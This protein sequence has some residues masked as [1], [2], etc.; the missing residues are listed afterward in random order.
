MFFQKGRH[1]S[2]LVGGPVVEDNVDFLLRFTATDNLIP[3]ANDLR[4]GMARRLLPCTFRVRTS[5]A[6]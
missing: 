4:A 2:R 6:A 3:E 5:R 1:F